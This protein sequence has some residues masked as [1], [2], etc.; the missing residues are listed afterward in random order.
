MG[1]DR[2]T[3]RQSV[4]KGAAIAS[5][6]QGQAL[7][8]V[9]AKGLFCALERSREHDLAGR[10]PRRCFRPLLLV[11]LLVLVAG[12]AS[13]RGGDASLPSGVSLESPF[14]VPLQVAENTAMVYAIVNG[15]QGALLMI[16]TGSDRT[17]ITPSLASRL[18][19]GVPDDAPRIEVTSFGGRKVEVPFVKVS[20]QVGDALIGDLDVGVYEA[21]PDG[22]ILDGLLGGD[23][24]YR[25]RV[26]LDKAA[27]RMRLEP[28]RGA[29]Q[30]VS[31][32]SQIA[33]AQLQ[34]PRLSPKVKFGRFTKTYPPGGTVIKSDLSNAPAVRE[35]FDAEHDAMVVFLYGVYHAFEVVNME[36]SWLDPSGTLVHRVLRTDDTAVSNY[37]WHCYFSVMRTQLMREKPGVWTV[38]LRVDDELMGEYS[39]RLTTN[40]LSYRH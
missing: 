30:V 12:C 38:Q 17:F 39:F 15:S 3:V 36:V 5:T 22:P 18:G 25:F 35:E 14:Q 28:L 26:T 4:S 2:E 7:V 37:L 24:L 31:L 20:V 34:L 21:F 40:R 32:S 1:P 13:T 9:I 19:L 27:R 10:E 11:S 23:F 8:R 6:A 29:G 33:E 16:D